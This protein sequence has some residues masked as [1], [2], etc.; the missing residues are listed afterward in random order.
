MESQKAL[1]DTL[2]GAFQKLQFHRAPTVKLSKFNGNPKRPGEL[3]LGEWVDELETYCRQLDLDE[4]NRVAVLLDY[5]GGVARDEV[6][7]SPPENRKNI[8]KLIATLNARFGSSE[9]VQSLNAAFYARNQREGESLTDFSR[10]LVVI[11]NRIE[12]AAVDPQEGEANS[13]LREKALTAVY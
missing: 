7:C 2:T 11:Y 10:A 1:A 13:R 3:T 6:F 8:S 12:D 9:S 4:P 5:L